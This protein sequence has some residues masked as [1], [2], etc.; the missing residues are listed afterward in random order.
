LATYSR[1][2][3][4]KVALD[5]LKEQ[6]EGKHAANL[7][8]NGFNDILKR[9]GP[10][11]TELLCRG[12]FLRHPSLHILAKLYAAK[13][14]ISKIDMIALSSEEE[15]IHRLLAQHSQSSARYQCQNC[16]FRARLFHWQCP[17]C[18]QWETFPPMQLEK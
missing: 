14:E 17:G 9:F 10:K 5:W 8:L 4:D 18:S 6:L 3:Q 12:V 13:I 16:G 11:E 2:N 1:L 15:T 7:I